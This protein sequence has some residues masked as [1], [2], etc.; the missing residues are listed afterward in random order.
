MGEKSVT[1]P[2]PPIGAQI[3][4]LRMERG[5]TLSELASL[6]GTSAA[7]MHRYESGW[8]RFELKTLRKI[9]AAL[10]SDLEVRLTPR[11]EPPPSVRPS[12]EE[13]LTLLGPLFWDRKLQSDDLVSHRD[14]VLG[15]VL[16]FGSQ[17]QAAAARSYYGDEAILKAIRRRGMDPRTRNYWELILEEPCIP[18]S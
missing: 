9:A 10:E 8:D 1:T 16:M 14:W 4:H 18:R 17:A 11:P 15:R 7:T 2:V 13:I 6:A 12:P 5:L 3:R